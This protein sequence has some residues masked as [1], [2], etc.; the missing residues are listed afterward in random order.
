MT[1]KKIGLL[2][3]ASLTFFLSI[4]SFPLFIEKII[5]ISKSDTIISIILGSLLTLIIFKVI[6]SLRKKVKPKNKYLKIFIS[7]LL[8]IIFIY[9]LLETTTFI[10]DT[11]L[12]SGNFY[13]TLILLLLMCLVISLREFKELTSLSLILLF[14]FI[15]LFIINIIGSSFSI[16]LTYLKVPFTSSITNIINGGLLFFVY[17]IIPLSLLL[18]IPYKEIDSLKKQDKYLYLAI[19][20]GIIVIIIDYLLLY[21]SSSI[22]VLTSYNYPFMLTINSLSSTFILGRLSYLISF[23]LLFSQLTTLSLIICVIKQLM[24]NNYTPKTQG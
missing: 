22:N 21:F 20:S 1:N 2:Q 19:I 23:Y 10:K 9:L 11:Y 4:S 15:P 18:F 12:S 7:I 3:L 17:E 13:S 16:D 6:L 8:S 5:K 24:W 14:I